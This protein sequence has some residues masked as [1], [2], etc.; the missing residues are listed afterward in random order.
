MPHKTKAA[1]NL[2]EAA[3]EYHR[4]PRPGKLEI[5][6]TK[7]LSN[8]RDLALAYSPGVAF[9]CEEIVR[10]PAEAFNMT[11]RGNLVGVVTNGTAVLGLGAIGPLAAKPVMEGKAVLFKKFAGIDCFDIEINELDPDKLVDIIASLEPT[12]GGINLE[13][14]KAPEC[15]YVERKLRERM[16]IPVFHDDQHGTAIIVG[17][18]ILNGLRVVGKK[19]E[20]VKVVT[21]G[22]GAAAL[23]CLD[24]LVAIG[25]KRENIWASDIRGV[26]YQGRVEEMDDNKARYAQKTDL[27]TVDQLLDGA[28]VFLGLSA[29]RVIKPE[30]LAKMAQ[31]PLIFALANPEPEIMPDLAKAARPDAIIATGRTDYPNQINNVLCFPFIFRGALDV[32]A[33]VVNE[34]MK[35]AAVKAIADLAMAE[36]ND[37]V[38]AAYGDSGT[39]SFGPEYLIPKPFDPRLIVRIAPAVA[40]AAMD[41]GVAQRPIKDFDAYKQQLAQF[42][43]HSGAVM[44][45]I[46]SAAK[47]SPK[48]VVFAEG[49]EERVMRAIQ[50]VIDEGIAHPIVIA[51]PA[52]FAQRVEKFGLRMTVGVD[53]E[54]VNPEQDAR[55]RDYWQT[56]HQLTQRKGVTEQL[57]KIEMRRRLTLIGSM[58]VRK[59]DADAMIC[60]TFGTHDLHLH[61]IDQVL[62]M[63]KDA[64]EYAAMNGIMLPNRLV[65]LVD[66]HVN[67]DPTAE[68][69]AEITIMAAEE[70]R[71][72]GI[73]PKV[74]LLSHSNFGTS[75]HPSA[76][77][78]RDTLAILR[79]KAPT[80]EV[81]GE[82][83]GD[84][85]LDEESRRGIES[86]L[87]GSANLLVCPNI[88]AA[89]IAYNLLKTGAGN[90]VAIGPI[91]LGCA[92]PVHILTPSATVRRIVNMA[93]LAVVDANNVR[94]SS[95][96]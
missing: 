78:M 2:K 76:V 10:D 7:T 71:R 9:A 96:L 5:S 67:Y 65:F 59:G 12:F 26:V 23:A 43:Y 6:A 32:G 73:E 70:L 29:A 30:W 66:T 55:Y 16:K 22:A 33:T 81:D 57:A 15:F 42:V 13:D 61:Y 83:H 1:Q 74:A 84:S 28:D 19:P 68:Q 49:E 69:L 18:G 46:F 90:N 82:M 92:K 89:N 11:S 77:K 36:Q 94:Q 41:S 85:A 56:Y 50:V 93:A 20:D 8:Q 58:M 54:L 88:D 17:A 38:A 21:S 14:I 27:R 72:F 75:N 62:G 64:H 39:L 95:L 34:A 91:L 35:L 4:L 37:Q 45:P 63:R 87:T 53:V 79:S 24:M 40:K 80:M 25:I 48:R 47:K 44:K 52:V 51:R 31:S 3:L 60:G 86:T